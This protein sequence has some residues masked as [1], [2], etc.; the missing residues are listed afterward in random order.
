MG[1]RGFRRELVCIVFWRGGLRLGWRFWCFLPCLRREKRRGLG[2]MQRICEPSSRIFRDRR[3][4]R[5]PLPGGKRLVGRVDV[6]C[7]RSTAL[8]PAL[9]TASDGCDCR[10]DKRGG[11]YDGGIEGCG[12]VCSGSWYDALG[13]LSIGPRSHVGA[14]L[15]PCK[16]P[17]MYTRLHLHLFLLFIPRDSSMPTHAVVLRYVGFACGVQN[18]IQTL[19]RLVETS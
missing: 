5:D 6:C 3:A 18:R 16:A 8:S 15:A 17:M 2:R 19:K 10:H 7:G 11:S 13:A 14:E 9:W 12:T 4:D 1:I